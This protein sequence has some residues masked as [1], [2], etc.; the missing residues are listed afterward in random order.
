MDRIEQ[1][2]DAVVK[3][4]TDTTA[5]GDTKLRPEK[6][7]H[8]FREIEAHTPLLSDTRR[9][10]MLSDKRDIDRVGMRSAIFHAP[11]TEGSVITD[12]VAPT[13]TNNQL[14]V[15]RV[16]GV[17]PVTDEALED[18]L[19]REGLED[20]LL[21]L[22]AERSAYDL[23]DLFLNGIYTS[24]YDTLLKLLDGW[25]NDATHSVVGTTDFTK[26][27]PEDMFDTM[28]RKL[29]DNNVEFMA[30]RADMTFWVSW[31]IERDYRGELRER[32]TVLGD[33]H[34][35]EA[36]SLA[37]EGIKVVPV[38]TIPEGSALLSINDNLVWGVRRDVR[39]EPYRRPTHSRTDFVVTARV[40]CDY[41]DER[42]AV[43]ATSYT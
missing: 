31:L 23:E 40:D 4:I 35:T 20:S 38:Y 18:N 10:D 15:V 11:P 34:I 43:K 33:T 21:S 6:F 36:P 27:D 9:I 17:V 14:S 24:P 2:V 16:T 25:M 37:Y 28:L 39:I 1:M 12:E 30:R 3:A 29:V 13:F 22:I 7:E 32:G 5:V 42:G 41:V 19:E 8:L 26:D